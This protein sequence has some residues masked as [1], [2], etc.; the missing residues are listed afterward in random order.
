MPNLIK[1]LNVFLDSDGLLRV[2]SKF[3]S[4]VVD[5]RI[6]EPIL[7]SKYSSLA[8]LIISSMHKNMGHS[9]KYS[10]LAQIRKEFYIP[11]MFSKVKF[12]IS[13]CSH[14][15]R[16]NSK[17]ISLNQ[18]AYRDERVNPSVI[19]FRNMYI[20][21]FG[22]YNVR[23]G[24]EKSKIYILLFT[25]MY[26]RAFNAEICTDM[27]VSQFL[28]AFQL[29]CH[30]Y[31]M[32]ARITSDPG[33]TLIAGGNSIMSFV[34]DEAVCT[35]LS[36][37]GIDK[38]EF[39]QYCKGNSSLGGLIESGVKLYK[40]LIFGFIRNNCLDMMD[41]LFVLSDVNHL[42]N[43]RPVALI[44]ASR[45]NSLD[46][47][48]VI[49]PEM[50]IRGHTLP[51]VNCIA[52]LQPIPEDPDWILN[53]HQKIKDSF[54]KLRSVRERMISSYNTEFYTKLMHQ[55][56]DKTSRYVP[57]QHVKLCVGDIVCLKEK[58]CKANNYPLAIVKKVVMND[59]DEVTSATVKRG[60]TGEIVNRHSAALIP[61]L[62]FNSSYANG[63]N[64]IEKPS[65][66]PRLST[67]RKAAIKASAAIAEGFL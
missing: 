50:L 66:V 58:F 9:G 54:H 15:K 5:G 56:V 47:P 21:H 55:A 6:Y 33:S 32:P 16:L 41:F 11:S 49:T 57:K 65:E 60:D 30:K 17:P 1:Q 40:R 27:T 42:I 12:V 14:C 63:E 53:S 26:T 52:E 19:P 36:Q 31:G 10:V 48:E 35:Y 34:N 13:K 45:D 44:D 59:L 64:N 38:V 23:I 37:Y 20:D 18:S 25:C 39:R 67:K 51:S 61:L 24:K 28:R 62:Q 8:D 3:K 2:R 4:R 22:P 43:K 7:L 29:H 46:V